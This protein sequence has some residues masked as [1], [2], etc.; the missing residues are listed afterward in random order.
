[1]IEDILDRLQGAR[2]FSTLDLNNGFFHVPIAED[3]IKYTAF[4]THEGQY[5]FLKYPYLDYVIAL[6]FFSGIGISKLTMQNIALYY[7]DD[8]IITSPDETSGIERLNMVLQV[9]RDYGLEIKKKKCQILKQRVPFLGIIIENGEVQ[10]SQEKTKAIDKF[11][12]PTT[13]KQIQ[14][15][16][17]LT[18]YFRKFILSYSVIAKPLSDLLKKESIFKF[19]EEQERSFNTLKKLLSETELHTDASKHGMV[20]VCFKNLTMMPSFIL[21][22]I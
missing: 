3:N 16:L 18:G 6:Q 5:E 10:P 1:M 14:S 17:G 13:I 21:F 22:I 8:L 11:S 2:Y 7:M 15:F 12:K 20:L 9:A 4:V 19:G